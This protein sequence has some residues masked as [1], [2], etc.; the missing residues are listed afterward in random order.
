[1]EL[2]MLFLYIFAESEIAGQKGF[3]NGVQN[4][5]VHSSSP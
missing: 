3:D 1:M 5:S 2:F 4:T